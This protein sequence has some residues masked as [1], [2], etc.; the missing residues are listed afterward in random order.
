MK[1]LRRIIISVVLGLAAFVSYKTT[2]L[3]STDTVLCITNALIAT[4]S[5]LAALY[6]NDLVDVIIKKK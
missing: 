1:I 3:G 6:I 5:S 2:D 4:G